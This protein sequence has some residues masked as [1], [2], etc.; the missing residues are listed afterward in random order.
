MY[1]V[2]AHDA[3]I[4]EPAPGIQNQVL[5]DGRPGVGSQHIA[6]VRARYGPG[7]AFSEHVHDV[8]EAFIVV[9]GEA[10][11]VIN[12][13]SRRLKGGD[14]ALVPANVPHV[15]SNASQ[16]EDLIVVGAF[17]ASKIV[18]RPVT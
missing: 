2:H 14:A 11:S 4:T 9:K 17:A 13:Q 8:E 5:I 3:E 10:L 15:L 6:L 18:R 1:W 16:T 12:G 7:V